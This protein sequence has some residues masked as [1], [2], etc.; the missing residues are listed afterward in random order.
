MADDAIDGFLDLLTPDNRAWL[1]SRPRDE[2]V[3]CLTRHLE[4]ME[5]EKHSGPELHDVLNPETEGVALGDLQDP[6][7]VANALVRQERQRGE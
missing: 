6:E 3:A 5:G 2:Q 1:E 4:V 7:K